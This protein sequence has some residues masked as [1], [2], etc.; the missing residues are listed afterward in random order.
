MTINDEVSFLLLAWLIY[1]RVLTS[2]HSHL[3]SLTKYYP[4]KESQFPSLFY[5]LNW[6][7]GLSEWHSKIYIPVF[8][9]M[10]AIL[11]IFLEEYVL[12]SLQK[13]L[14]WTRVYLNFQIIF[15]CGIIETLNHQDLLFFNYLGGQ[16]TE[17]AKK[18]QL[19]FLTHALDL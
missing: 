4:S 19:V 7:D 10:G 11:N 5:G 2:H 3:T 6:P 14:H 18:K 9:L 12:E 16:V 13:M 1:Q 15:L 17:V 8:N